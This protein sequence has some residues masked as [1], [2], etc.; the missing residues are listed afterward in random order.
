MILSANPAE[1][2]KAKYDVVLADP[3]WMYYGD[4]SRDQC[5]GKHYDMMSDRDVG[6][7]PVRELMTKRSVLFLWATSPKLDVAVSMIGEWG[8]HFRGVAFVWVKT[9]QAGKIINA[10]GVR[11]SIVKSTTEYVLAA[12]PVA[13]GRPLPLASEKV[14][15]VILAARPDNRHSAK[16]SAIFDRIEEL[17]P[18]AVSVEL[19]CRG[20]SHTGW[21]SWGAEAV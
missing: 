3:P 2:P 7:L 12:S 13:K 17:Y 1:W 21:D 5:C 10:Q 19:F 4:Q 9:T 18:V 16:P 6:A 20:E 15:Q 11:P 14:A 8:L